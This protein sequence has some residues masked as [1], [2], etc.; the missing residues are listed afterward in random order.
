VQ[1]SSF[2]TNMVPGRCR[3]P[4]L[5]YRSLVVRELD[6]P[7]APLQTACLTI[8]QALASRRLWP[9][10]EATVGDSQ[11]SAWSRAPVGVD[12]ASCPPP[13]SHPH[14]GLPPLA[15]AGHGLTPPYSPRAKGVA[16]LSPDP[17]LSLLL[18][19]PPSLRISDICDELPLP[20]F[21]LLSRSPGLAE[22]KGA[23][24]KLTPLAG[25]L[26]L[27]CAADASRAVCRRMLGAQCVGAYGTRL[28]LGGYAADARRA[29][30]RCE[31][32]SGAQGC[33][34]SVKRWTVQILPHFL[35]AGTLHSDCADF[36]LPITKSPSHPT[37]HS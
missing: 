12:H 29:C 30:R 6:N 14:R 9:C 22:W 11:N 7:P 24:T 13:S 20:P 35:R 1:R 4:T 26:R 19:R 16:I 28:C 36:S 18:P 34:A 32:L 17:H 27:G 21:H 33:T 2:A 23:C 3:V 25:S 8:P 10:P 5:R 31:Y 37:P 15:T